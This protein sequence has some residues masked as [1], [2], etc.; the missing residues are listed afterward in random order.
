M[1]A[2]SE[3]PLEEVLSSF[4][5]HIGF[6]ENSDALEIAAVLESWLKIVG[7]DDGE[8]VAWEALKQVV[9]EQLDYRFLDDAR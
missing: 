8:D 3:P 4:G 9:S 7:V 1:T 2:I 6:H 5:L